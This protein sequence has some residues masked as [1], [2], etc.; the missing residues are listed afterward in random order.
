MNR[1]FKQV[2]VVPRRWQHRRALR[3][4]RFESEHNRGSHF[5][6]AGRREVWHFHRLFGGQVGHVLHVQQAGVL[7]DASRALAEPQV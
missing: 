5:R 7:E 4:S 1:A 6:H 2:A 3:A